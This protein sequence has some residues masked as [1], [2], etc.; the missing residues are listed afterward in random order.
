MLRLPV[1]SGDDLPGAHSSQVYSAPAKVLHLFRMPV[2]PTR[3]CSVRLM[4][5]IR[6]GYGESAL[7]I[8]GEFLIPDR[9]CEASV[10]HAEIPPVPTLLGQ[11]HFKSDLGVARR[12][13][14]TCHAA[15]CRQ[16]THRR[17][18]ALNLQLTRRHRFSQGDARIRKLQIFQAATVR[19]EQH[20][21]M[22]GQQT[23]EHSEDS[24]HLDRQP[25]YLHKNSSTLEQGYLLSDPKRLINYP[26]YIWMLNSPESSSN[27]N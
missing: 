2:G 15:E 9:S 7:Q 26:T 1:V 8:I 4:S 18:S 22:Y 16:I 27:R 11:P 19:G 24:D 12:P 10:A 25:F 5:C 20:R 23:S 3:V 21:R 6:P 14:Q 13:Q 17:F